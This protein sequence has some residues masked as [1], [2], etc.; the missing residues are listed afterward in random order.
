VAFSPDGRTLVIGGHDGLVRLWAP[1]APVDGEA[2]SVRLWVEWLTGA[3]L[4]PGGAIRALA[5]EGARTRRRRPDELGW[6]LP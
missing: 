6:T 2:G 4:D 5:P 1:P 3:E